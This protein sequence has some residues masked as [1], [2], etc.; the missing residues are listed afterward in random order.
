[1]SERDLA[2]ISVSLLLTHGRSNRLLL[3]RHGVKQNEQETWGLI[4]GGVKYREN[5][6][7]AALREAEEESKLQPKNIIFVKGRNDIRPHVALVCGN[8][9]NH[10]GL[11]FDV[12]YSGP[13]TPNGWG[14]DDDA[15]VDRV[16]WFTWQRVLDLIDN[17]NSIYRPEFNL[18]Q[19]VR[20][21]MM[22]HGAKENRVA[23]VEG[24]LRSR[25]GRI[26]GL[27]QETNGKIGYIPPYDEWMVMPGLRGD[28]RKTNFA[29]KRFHQ[30]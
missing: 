30:E 22:G 13:K 14:I 25:V 1:M 17:P 24:W 21:T 28:P 29:R 5:A 16:E 27:Y 9:M 3:T 11:V 18:P 20:W 15:K 19:L 23:T 2:S 10:E 7:K 12:T 8:D 26:E 4:A 6:W